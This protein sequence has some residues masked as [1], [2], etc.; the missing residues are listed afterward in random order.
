MVQTWVDRSEELLIDLLYKMAKEVGYSFDKVSLK[1]GIYSPRAH[2]ELEEQ[3]KSIREG[4]WRL[5]MVKSLFL[6]R[7]KAFL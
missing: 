7:L 2:G 4:G 3:F 6:W 5:L 1:R